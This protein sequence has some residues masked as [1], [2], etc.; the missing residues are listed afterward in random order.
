MRMIILL[1]VVFSFPIFCEEDDAEKNKKIHEIFFPVLNTHIASLEK[2]V[3]EFEQD[4]EQSKTVFAKKEL[5]ISPKQGQNF[6]FLLERILN[7][8]EPDAMVKFVLDKDENN[9]RNRMSYYFKSLFDKKRYKISS[10]IVNKHMLSL[11]KIVTEFEQDI[12]QRKTVLEGKKLKA[13]PE[14]TK[15][16]VLLLD[17]ISDKSEKIGVLEIFNE[18]KLLERIDKIKLELRESPISKKL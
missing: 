1:S 16:F 18:T 3:N 5:T 10:Q 9:L 15:K 7:K 11:A 14:Q 2:I 17:R 4:I 12:D 8:F 13:L 6:V